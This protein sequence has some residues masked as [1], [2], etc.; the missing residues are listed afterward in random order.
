MKN[1]LKI[2][3]VVYQTWETTNYPDEIIEC[4]C[5]WDSLNPGWEFRRYDAR[6][7]REFIREHMP[8]DVLSAYDKLVP[9]AYQA[10]L[11]RYCVLFVKGGVYMDINKAPLNPLDIL[12]PINSDFVAISNP[13][14]PNN[15]PAIQN[16]FIL[17]R[18][19]CKILQQVIRLIVNNVQN[20]VYGDDSLI[21]TG[22][23]AFALA[24]NQ[25]LRRSP[26]AQFKVGQQLYGKTK[27]TLWYADPKKVIIDGIKTGIVYT[28]TDKSTACYRS[29]MRSK[30]Y[31]N[32]VTDID[33]VD[34]EQYCI[35]NYPF[36]WKY[37]LI[38][39]DDLQRMPRHQLTQHIATDMVERYYKLG[40]GN[41]AQ[42]L[43]WS[44]LK[45]GYGS[46]TLLRLLLKYGVRRKLKS[47]LKV[48]FQNRG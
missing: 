33:A 20:R 26:T 40:K 15:L 23:Q 6:A 43:A 31:D 24:M 42:K 3:K 25:V 1:E 11:W 7:R 44:A 14:R 17:A 35:R 34:V 2:P 39:R 21:P 37:G 18:K 29:M 45:K 10:D 16:T 5:I 12:L 4:C 41:Q 22:P 9:G 28:D 13:I 46:K 47:G 19:G 48:V 36:A 8:S 32:D 38:Y 30:L 27:I